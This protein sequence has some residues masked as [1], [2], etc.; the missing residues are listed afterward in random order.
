MRIQD[1][2]RGEKSEIIVS[3]WGTGK[4]PKQKFNLSKAGKRALAFGAAWQWRFV[5]FKM[6]SRDFVVRLLFCEDKSK[7][8]MH[9]AMKSGRDL[10]VLCS[11]E[12]HA[13]HVT[14]WH[15]HTLCGEQNDIDTAP[16][17]T[18]VHGPWVKRLPAAR[19]PHRRTAFTKDKIGGLNA[20][21]WREAMR[22]FK[23]DVKGDLV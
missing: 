5:E 4:I 17:G 3:D 12:F 18:L 14:G 6:G 16:K 22:F 1:V 13:D 23:I 15:L 2:I 20:W 21:L 19:Q 11:Y 10:T 8:H 7:A 9:L